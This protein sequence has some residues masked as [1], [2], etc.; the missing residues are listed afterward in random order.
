M[1]SHEAHPSDN[2]TRLIE[3]AAR[4]IVDA[5][6]DYNARF[7]DI[8][9]RAA[10]H[11]DRCD[12]TAQQQSANQRIGLYDEC[13]AETIGRLEDC[14]AERLLARALWLDIHRRY[15]HA[16]EARIDAELYK[17]FFNTI[18]RRLFK[19]RGVSRGMEFI[20]LDIEPTEHIT[21]P[22]D[23]Y[24]Y[25]C[26]EQ[27]AEAMQRMLADA[28]VRYRSE[29]LETDAKAI[30]ERLKM[31]LHNAKGGGLL[32]VELL[33]I[34][35]YR[36]RRAYLIGR[37]FGHER[38]LPCVIALV[39]DQDG[40]RADAVITER[41]QISVLFGFTYS[42][43]HADLAT[44]GDAVVFLRTLLPNKPVDELYTVLGRIKQG[45]TERYRHFVKH[46]ISA[47]REQ[48]IEAEGQ[49]GMVMLVFTLPSYPLVFKLVR[50][51]FAPGKTIGR[52][53]VLKQY[54]LVFNHDRVGR[55]IDA[56]E[57]R[58]LQFDRRLFDDD[59]IA[60]LKRECARI[61]KVEKNRV[62]VAHCFIQRRVRPLDLFIQ[63]V[64]SAAAERIILDYGQ[65]IRDMA[66][67]NLFPGD[68]FLKNFGVTASQRVIFYDFDEVSRVTDCNF[69]RIPPARSE[70]ELMSEERWFNVEPGDAFPE[71]FEQF[72]DL[73]PEHRAFFAQHHGELF[74]PSWW[75]TLHARL[76]EH[77]AG[78]VSPYSDSVR[79][80]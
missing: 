72:M 25:S 15:A 51:H 14:L 60:L 61:V 46:L 21:H 78:D 59:L 11:F 48:M 7:S 10:R 77:P 73:S 12:W 47:Q 52:E 54:R 30:A 68:L 23:R 37:V 20:A 57:Y 56:Q 49:R 67:S 29:T 76:I 9:R 50:D 74:D 44:I 26:R 2:R 45:K 40:V 4:L 6:D 53:H 16:I 43:F 13:I 28:H 22:I 19:T 31:D 8:T 1:S 33:K 80:R 64:K 24:I 38:W 62:T 17:T 69:R 75:Q 55:L 70:H 27:P 41:L 79:L 36:D 5:F 18:T 63:E 58:H 34:V 66:R 42:Y 39:N 32:S 35:F 71:Q 65:A 3:R